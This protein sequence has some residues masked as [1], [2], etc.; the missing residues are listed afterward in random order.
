MKIHTQ[1][2]IIILG[3]LIIGILLGGVLSTV[4]VHQRFQKIQSMLGPG[5]F[6]EHLIDQVI[7]PVDNAQREKLIAIA[8]STAVKSQALIGQFHE[9]MKTNMDSL[10]TQ[11]EPLLT[12]DQYERFKKWVDHMGKMGPRRKPGFK[13]GR[14][15]HQ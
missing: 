11:V 14:G 3:T 5:H 2:A 4:F 15:L 6:S 7:Q 9:G 8:E 1:S 13:R 12:K 10:L